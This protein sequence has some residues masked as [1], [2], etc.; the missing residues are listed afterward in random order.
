MGIYA[1]ICNYYYPK[2]KQFLYVLH[3]FIVMDLAAYLCAGNYIS[4]LSHASEP[5]RK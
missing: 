4:Y 3:V 5:L 2:V 1:R